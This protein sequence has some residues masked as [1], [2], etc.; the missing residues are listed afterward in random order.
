MTMKTILK[1]LTLYYKDY[2][3]GGWGYIILKKSKV[4]LTILVSIHV[5]CIVIVLWKSLGFPILCW[6]IHGGAAKGNKNT[7]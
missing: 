1:R 4:D 2:L 5:F 7:K 3:T 6:W